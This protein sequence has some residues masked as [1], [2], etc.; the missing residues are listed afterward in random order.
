MPVQS[1]PGPQ[2]TCGQQQQQQW[3]T[4]SRPASQQAKRMQ[5][6][7][8]RIP[9][10]HFTGPAVHCPVRMCV[11]PSIVVN[12]CHICQ[13]KSIEQPLQQGRNPPAES[14][15][16]LSQPP[17]SLVPARCQCHHCCCVFGSSSCPASLQECQ[18]AVRQQ[19]TQLRKVC[20]PHWGS[21]RSVCSTDLCNCCCSCWWGLRWCWWCSRQGLGCCCCLLL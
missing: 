9:Q 2:T 5:P 3:W 4:N 20:C 7:L 13:V 11:L 10:K 1:S 17:V 8:Q 6:L 16:S 19:R 14:C 12:V 18:A 15:Q 21:V